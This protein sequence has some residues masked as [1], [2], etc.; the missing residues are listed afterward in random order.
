M[1]ASNDCAFGD[2]E[3][4]RI[5]REQP[6]RMATAARIRIAVLAFIGRNLPSEI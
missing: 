6:F 3:R 1:A 4:P 5:D 2:G